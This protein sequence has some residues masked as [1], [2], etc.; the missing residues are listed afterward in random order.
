MTPEQITALALANGF[1]LKTQP[2]GTK[3]LNPYVLDFAR[4]LL[5]NT[6]AAK[7]MHAKRH[8]DGRGRVQC[9]PPRVF[10]RRLARVP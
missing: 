1:K 9:G 7:D 6:T 2:D 5:E 3:A 8:A 10:S 4:A